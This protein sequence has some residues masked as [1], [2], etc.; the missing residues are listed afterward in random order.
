MATVN[1]S[2]LFENNIRRVSEVGV[3]TLNAQLSNDGDR[4]SQS[5]VY[6]A[7]ADTYTVYNIPADSLVSKVYF[8]VDEAF[9]ASTTAAISTI[10]G[11]PVALVAALDCA[12]VGASVSTAVDLYFDTVDGVA[13][14]L[15]DDVTQGKLRIVTVF[16]SASTNSDSYIDLGA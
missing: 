7:A 4:L 12:T 16:A 3:A 11:T 15:S 9:D 1:L 2:N 8:I 6:A 10:A 5:A 13:I 14:T